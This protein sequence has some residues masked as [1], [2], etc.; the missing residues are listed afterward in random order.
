MVWPARKKEMTETVVNIFTSLIKLRTKMVNVS[1]RQEL[2]QR[3][4]SFITAEDYQ[5]VFETARKS[6]IRSRTSACPSTS[7]CTS[8]VKMN[9]IHVLNSQTYK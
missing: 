4:N 9:V 8:T 3:T 6:C 2:D 7:M 5:W 1:K